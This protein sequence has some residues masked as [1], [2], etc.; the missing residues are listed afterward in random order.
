LI[1]VIKRRILL[2]KS[3]ILIAA[4]AGIV[5]CIS[6][7]VIVHYLGILFKGYHPLKEPMSIIGSSVSPFAHQISIWW[8]VQGILL[9]V[10]AAGFV[11][12]FYEIGKTTRIAGI[13]IMVYGLGE[14]VATGAIPVEIVNNRLTL[15]GYVHDLLGGIGVAAVMVL[16]FVMR[17]L[18]K[19]SGNF[20]LTRFSFFI[21]ICGILFFGMFTVAKVLKTNQ[22]IFAY[23]GLWQRLSSI[24]YYLYFI[25]LAILMLNR[26][27]YSKKK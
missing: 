13:L 9:N 25:M 10:F 17:T 27:I 6:D 18:F 20:R 8:V 19:I 24:N 12:A 11:V 3:F 23:G 2:K 15:Q 14:G 4:L 5:A 22:G 1:E 21:G 26:S 7:L 16:P